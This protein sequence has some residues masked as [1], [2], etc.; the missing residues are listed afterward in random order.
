[1]SDQRHWSI[2]DAREL[3]C[4]KGAREVVDALLARRTDAQTPAAWISVP[5]RAELVDRADEIDR[6][7]EGGADL[8]LAG[9]PFAVK[10]NIDVAGVATTAGCPE[11]AYVPTSSAP[12]VA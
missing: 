9:V 7:L 4:T 12:V 1:M 10:D 8:P 2:A 6:L 3:A 11:F 5:S